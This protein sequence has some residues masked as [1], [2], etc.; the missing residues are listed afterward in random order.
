MGNCRNKRKNDW[1]TVETKERKY[2][3]YEP[4]FYENGYTKEVQV[5]YQIDGSKIPL[6]WSSK[7]LDYWG[8]TTSKKSLIKSIPHHKK[9]GTKKVIDKAAYDETVITGYKCSCGATK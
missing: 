9:V 6:E 1:V 4:E 7:C 5:I 2:E 8:S 3:D